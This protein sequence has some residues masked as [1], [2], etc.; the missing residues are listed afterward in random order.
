MISC[1]GV[2]CD[3]STHRPAVT[4]CH[5]RLSSR[6]WHSRTG[7]SEPRRASAAAAAARS[8]PCPAPAVRAAGERGQARGQHRDGGSSD[9]AGEQLWTYRQPCRPHTTHCGLRP[10]HCRLTWYSKGHGR[11]TVQRPCSRLLAQRTTGSAS[12]GGGS[13]ACRCC[14]RPWG[15]VAGPWR[16]RAARRA[17]C[18]AA[19][20]AAASCWWMK[21]VSTWISR[22]AIANCAVGQWG[23]G[24]G[25]WG[26]A[27][28]C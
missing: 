1:Q 24:A 21:S 25:S 4:H 27:L 7:S 22:S 5:P 13:A 12:G 28:R 6:A 20:S 18:S 10:P 16:R 2:Q 23:G 14:C 19:A 26:T 3:A 8:C 9:R 15:Q 11:T 17:A